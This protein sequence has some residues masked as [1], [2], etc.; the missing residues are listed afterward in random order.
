MLTIVIV[1]VIAYL[2]GSFP[3]AYLI[4]KYRHHRDI[5]REGTGN[6]GARNSL[7]VTGSRATFLVVLLVDLLKGAVSV[8]GVYYLLGDSFW[9]GAAA[10]VGV[11]A[12]HNYSPWIGFKGG[13]GLAPAAGAMLVFNPVVVAY[14]VVLWLIARWR[15]KNVHWGNIWA[16]MLTPVLVASAK[17]LSNILNLFSPSSELDIFYATLA[18]TVLILLRHIEPLRELLLHKNAKD[19]G[20]NPTV[21]QEDA[22]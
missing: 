7:D 3:T 21:K 4:V 8:A 20:R 5:R 10:V 18:F 1:A 19:D 11:V 16:T 6:V 13:R 2:A 17:N 22:Q 15:L 14:W 9:P 12:G